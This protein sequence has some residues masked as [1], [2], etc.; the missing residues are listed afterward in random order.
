LSNTEFLWDGRRLLA[1]QALFEGRAPYTVP[2]FALF[3]DH[4]GP[5]LSLFRQAVFDGQIDTAIDTAQQRFTQ[6]L[7]KP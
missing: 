7:Q 6:I 1:A 4:A 2:Y 5:L 3:N